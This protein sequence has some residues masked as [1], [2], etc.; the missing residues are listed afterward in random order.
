MKR[1]NKSHVKVSII[2][3]CH[4]R[5]KDLE[6]LLKSIFTQ[7][8]K[9]Y[10][11][12]VIDDN[13]T[14]PITDYLINH[15]P[16]IIVIKNKKNMF[17]GFVRNQGAYI[18]KGEYLQFLDNDTAFQNKN[19]LA[20]SIDILNK[21]PDY[22]AVGGM[23]FPQDIDK[24]GNPQYV[25]SIWQE[26]LD[27][28]II[29]EKRGISKKETRC[30]VSILDSCGFMI[31]KKVFEEIGGFDEYFKY[32]HEDS[33]FFKRFNKLGYTAILDYNS[34]VIHYH[35]TIKSINPFFW[36][37][38][39]RV[40]FRL[41]HF[42]FFNNKIINNF[43]VPLFRKRGVGNNNKLSK[44]KTSFYDSKVDILYRK[45]IIQKVFI[46]SH[47]ILFANISNY[48]D[49][50]RIIKSRKQNFLKNLRLRRYVIEGLK[51]AHI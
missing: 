41:K 37:A 47:I 45:N 31:R 13:S 39:G 25:S 11:I 5:L 30:K 16:K 12:I 7:T 26:W 49:I 29:D 19:C 27:S 33:D 8:L 22:S 2:I 20:N 6:R 51:N 23:C 35:S 24:K 42:G 32:G 34:A 10:E 50:L 40:R 44:Q 18:A 14:E 4:N 28:H 36:R 43:D 46:I 48:I 1:E 38:R 17:P 3:P 15:Y 21:N 9:D